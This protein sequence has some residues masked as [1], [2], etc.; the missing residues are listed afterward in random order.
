MDSLTLQIESAIINITDKII[1]FLPNDLFI[2]LILVMMTLVI[3]FGIS[4][5]LSK[6]DQ[7][8]TN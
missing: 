5:L 6:E 3:V 4:R 1:S 7:E 2:R 8:D